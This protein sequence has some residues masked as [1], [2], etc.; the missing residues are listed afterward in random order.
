MQT[1]PVFKQASIRPGNKT[2]PAHLVLFRAGSL[3]GTVQEG[4][5]GEGQDGGDTNAVS[6]KQAKHLCRFV[7]NEPGRGGG[8]LRL[9]TCA[10][11]INISLC[12]NCSLPAD[13]H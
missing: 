11:L 6:G 7:R 10:K 9:G 8:S 2:V 1:A 3:R 5:L 12:S 13:W 4:L